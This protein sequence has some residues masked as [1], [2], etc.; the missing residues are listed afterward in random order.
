MDNQTTESRLYQDVK[1]HWEEAKQ[2]RPT[3]EEL[4]D[5]LYQFQAYFRSVADVIEEIV[6]R[7]RMYHSYDS[8]YNSL[9]NDKKLKN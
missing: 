7:E 9:K 8:L 4:F 1:K 5:R 3:F 6:N 2:N